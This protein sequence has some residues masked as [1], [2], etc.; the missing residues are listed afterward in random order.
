VVLIPGFVFVDPPPPRTVW[1]GANATFVM[2]LKSVNGFRGKVAMFAR[3]LPANQLWP[4]ADWNPAL[5]SLT[6]NAIGRST[7]TI[8]TDSATPVGTQTITVEGR[9][10]EIQESANVLLL[11][12]R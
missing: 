8:A 7:L 2:T 3:V 1:R 9:T 10:G 12:V 6:P 11:T 4:G 5:V